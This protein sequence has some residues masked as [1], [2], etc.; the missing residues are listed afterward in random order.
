[1]A[2][3]RASWPPLDFTIKSASRCNLDCTYC[4]V[5]NQGDD[6]WR[7]RPVTMPDH[8]FTAALERMRAYCLLSGQPSVEITFHGGEP[9]LIG[10]RRFSRWC[11]QA[12]D[13]LGDIVTVRFGI[14][15]NGTLVDEDWVHS[16]QSFDVVVGVSIDG[17]SE[18]H[19]RNRVD[20]QGRGSYD[21]VAKGI[22]RLQESG[23]EVGLLSV[24]QPGGDGL[25][26]HRHLLGLGVNQISYLFPH[27]THDTIGPV[28]ALFGPVPCAQYL[29]PILDFW[30]DEGTMDQQ[31]S[32]FWQMSR[33]ILGGRS[34]F[35]LFGNRPLAFVFVEPDG[36]IEGLDTL[37]V[38]T[39]G[40][41][42]TG[43]NVLTSG[44][45]SI[46]TA[47]E[48]HRQAIF[49][50]IPVPTGCRECVEVGTCAGGHL[51]DR[52]SQVRG[53]DNPS[54]WCQDLLE[55]FGHMR[56]LLEVGPDETALRRRALEELY[57]GT[58][59]ESTREDNK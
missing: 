53:F 7:D 55:L 10:A 19:D 20:R 6:S 29:R 8:V 54:V 50:G 45:D 5:Y 4:Y 31:I 34:G 59:S 13:V 49:D 25:S 1:M 15:T 52:F 11:G 21:R 57:A 38:G 16:F 14:Q 27:F 46:A 22:G 39:Q 17:P 51:A 26:V 3:S 33:V 12:R 48:L 58:L 56:A 28:R 44:F 18:T 37:R 36:S 24:I 9:C 43:L 32:I 41:A 47:S 2:V 23:V 35:D 42:E 40:L 30:W